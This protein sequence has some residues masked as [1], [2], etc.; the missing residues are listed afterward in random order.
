MEYGK[1]FEVC[2]L[3]NKLSSYIFFGFHSD[4][5]SKTINAI[6]AS[7]IS[8]SLVF[9]HSFSKNI[10]YVSTQL[11][12]IYECRVAWI[13]ASLLLELIENC[14]KSHVVFISLSLARFL[15]FV[16]Q[17]LLN[18]RRWQTPSNTPKR[19]HHAPAFTAFTTTVMIWHNLLLSLADASCGFFSCCLFHHALARLSVIMFQGTPINW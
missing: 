16:K 3:M 17:H 9:V 5:N 7:N 10:A 15:F 6:C 19:E 1:C 12:A 8:L 14:C 18:N 11:Q 13:I 2:N 4:S